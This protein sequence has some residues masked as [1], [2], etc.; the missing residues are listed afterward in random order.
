M[1]DAVVAEGPRFLIIAA[2]AI[3]TVSKERLMGMA[4]QGSKAILA[5][6]DDL[7][8]DALLLPESFMRACEQVKFREEDYRKLKGSVE[9]E[10][11]LV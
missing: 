8:H 4:R 5:Y 1:I 2:L 6:L 7:P 11:G 9:K 3:L 10:L